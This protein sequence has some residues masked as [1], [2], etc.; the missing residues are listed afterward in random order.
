[1]GPRPPTAATAAGAPVRGVPQYKYAAGVRNT[2]QHI[3]AQPQVSMQQVAPPVSDAP[4]CSR[5][6]WCGRRLRWWFFSVFSALFV[7]LEN[8]SS[9]H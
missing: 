2:Q 5:S 7:A 8:S 1:M 6:Q 4:Y 3:S 9:T